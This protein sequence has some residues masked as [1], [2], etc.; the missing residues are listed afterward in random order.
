MSVSV[1]AHD[2]AELELRDVSQY[3]ESES[4]GLG[5]AFLSEVEIAVNQIREYPEAVPIIHTIVRRKVIRRFRIV[6]CMWSTQTEYT[7]SPSRTNIAG[8]FIGV[9]G[10][11]GN[12][13]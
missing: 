3:Y 5:K 13:A 8:H 1:R 12:A 10:C 7:F 2:L 6:S 4:K 9:I 11:E